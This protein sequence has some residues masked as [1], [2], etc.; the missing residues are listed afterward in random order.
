MLTHD[1][2]PVIDYIQVGAGR[3]DQPQ[4]VQHILKT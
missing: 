2:E 3:Q 1:F 4:F